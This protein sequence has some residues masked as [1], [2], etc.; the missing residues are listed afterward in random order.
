MLTL[1]PDEADL[2]FVPMYASCHMSS[3]FVKPG[4]GWPVLVSFFYFLCVSHVFAFRQTGARL[5][6]T[7]FPCFAGTKVQILTQKALC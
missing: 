3:H 4:P 5:A 1:D 2:F 6:G 7:Q